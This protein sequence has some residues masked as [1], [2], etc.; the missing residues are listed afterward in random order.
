ME[1]SFEKIKKVFHEKGYTFFTDGD[2]NLNIVG[3]R[4]NNHRAGLFDDYICLLYYN[5][6]KESIKVY[7]AT[8]DPGLY[9][10]NNP[11]NVS[12]TAILKPGQYRSSHKIGKHR[13]QYL[14]LIQNKPLTVYRD[15]NKDEVLDFMNEDTGMFGINIHRAGWESINVNKW[16]AGCQ[17]FAYRRQYDEFMNIIMMSAKLYGDVF[18]Y[19]LLEEND[20]K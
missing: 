19:T 11:M 16:S 4:Y 14:A 9:W 18:T 5:S 12:G 1:L 3:V 20:L 7:R 8:T 17:V 6:L 15:N 10:L 13:G 2:F